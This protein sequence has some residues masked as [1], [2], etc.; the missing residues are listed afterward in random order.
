MPASQ[1]QPGPQ[2]APIL[3]EAARYFCTTASR[4]HIVGSSLSGADA[5]CFAPAWGLPLRVQAY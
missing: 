2:L 4:P 3:A 1:P 5:P